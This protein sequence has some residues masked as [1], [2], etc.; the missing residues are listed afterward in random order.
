MAL[1]QINDYAD[2][3]SEFA[4]RYAVMTGGG[5]DDEAKFRLAVTNRRQDL[6]FA[7]KVFPGIRSVNT[8]LEIIDQLYDL[9][10]QGQ[11]TTFPSA[12]RLRTVIDLHQKPAFHSVGDAERHKYKLDGR[13]PF[14][15]GFRKIPVEAAASA[16]LYS[17]ERMGQSSFATQFQIAIENMHHDGEMLYPDGGYTED[18]ALHDLLEQAR[19][20]VRSSRTV[21]PD[22][23]VIEVVQAHQT[24][25]YPVEA[26]PRKIA[27]LLSPG[28]MGS[29]LNKS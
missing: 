12:D 24:R 22:E 8:D 25:Q 21:L 7:G 23:A 3:L 29:G 9:A 20:S 13:S 28:P 15:D 2:P 27:W 18:L 5:A 26:P 14:V 4:Q 10:N 16:M 6:F 11:G 1:L 17:E 19:R